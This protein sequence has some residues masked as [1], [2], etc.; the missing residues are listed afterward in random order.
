MEHCCAARPLKSSHLDLTASGQL[1]GAGNVNPNYRHTTRA[2]P[3]SHSEP[4]TSALSTGTLILPQ[5]LPVRCCRSAMELDSRDCTLEAV[6]P[7]LYPSAYPYTIPNTSETHASSNEK[8][9]LAGDQNAPDVITP[10]R[11]R[12]HNLVR[13]PF[14]ILFG[15]LIAIIAGVI[16]GVIGDQVAKSRKTDKVAEGES[17][18]VATVSST[19]TPTSGGATPSSSVFVR[20]LGLPSS[21]CIPTTQQRAF[22][23]VSRYANTPY[24]TYCATGWNSDDIVSVSVATP[25]DCIEACQNFNSHKSASSPACVGAGFVVEWWDQDRA[26]RDTHVTPF[27]CYLKNNDT[28]TARNEKS[29]EVLSL[30]LGDA[31]SGTLKVGA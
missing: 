26:M 3:T 27:N 15:I 6:P 12:R 19:P 18:A 2:Y 16:G 11:Q 13:W 20:T 22:K 7:K 14:L 17:C 24:T 25:S 10:R 31:C 1:V 8:S 9:F 30:C 4:S 28:G 21:G 29:Y 23:S 5:A